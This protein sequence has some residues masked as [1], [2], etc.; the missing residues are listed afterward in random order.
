[1]GNFLIDEMETGRVTKKLRARISLFSFLSLTLP[2]CSVQCGA[3]CQGILYIAPHKLVN[4]T[5]CLA[6]L[7]HYP[8]WFSARYDSETEMVQEVSALVSQKLKL[9]IIHIKVQFYTNYLSLDKR[10]Q[11]RPLIWIPFYPTTSLQMKCISLGHLK[12]AH[13]GKDIQNLEPLS[14]VCLFNLLPP[15]TR[16]T[17]PL[18]NNTISGSFWLQHQWNKDLM[19]KKRIKF[20]MLAWEHLNTLLSMIKLIR[21][22]IIESTHMTFATYTTFAMVVSTLLSDP[23]ELICKGV[24]ISDSWIWVLIWGLKLIWGVMLFQFLHPKH[25]REGEGS[26]WL[27]RAEKGSC[28]VLGQEH[29]ASLR[30]CGAQLQPCPSQLPAEG[31]CHQHLQAQPPR[32]WRKSSPLRSKF[33]FAPWELNRNWWINAVLRKSAASFPHSSLPMASPWCHRSTIPQVLKAQSSYPQF[34][35]FQLQH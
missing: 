19:R 17:F 25:T 31:R 15:R 33:S 12:F 22:L 28:S 29:T 30:L 26:S 13:Y 24:F 14:A 6:I 1:M 32:S 8:Q 16:M 3:P 11:C 7:H 20:W 23:R 4:I 34:W 9:R 35:A 2:A 27:Y 10:L 18:Q 21:F 5:V